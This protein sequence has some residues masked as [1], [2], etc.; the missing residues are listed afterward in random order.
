M[1]FPLVDDGT[2]VRA[3]LAG[4]VAGLRAATHDV[5]VVLPV[6]VPYM[7]AAALH[8]LAD[9]CRD[10]A[11]PQDGA[12]ALRLSEDALPALER[13]LA[14]GQIEVRDLLAELDEA[15]VELTGAARQ[16]EYRG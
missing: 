1:P 14:E 13:G 5:T 16:R 11:V 12:A 2:E 15:V 7:T 3:A 9:A 8:R 6:D 4:I 10:A